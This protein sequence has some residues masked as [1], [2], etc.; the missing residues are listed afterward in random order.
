MFWSL[1]PPFEFDKLSSIFQNPVRTSQPFGTLFCFLPIISHFLLNHCYRILSPYW[2]FIWF[3]SLFT[4]SYVGCELTEEIIC[5]L[6]LVFVSPD[7]CIVLMRVFNHVF[8]LSCVELKYI[9][10]LLSAE[11]SNSMRVVKSWDELKKILERRKRQSKT[12]KRRIRR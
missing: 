12:L 2:Q 10:R 9:W 8:K 3:T 5:W 1:K 11:L 7:Y 6:V 4:I